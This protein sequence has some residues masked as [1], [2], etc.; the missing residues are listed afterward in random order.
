MKEKW[1]DGPHALTDIRNSIVHPD[2]DKRPEFM[3]DSYYQ[4]CQLSLWYLDLVFLRLC[5]HKGYYANRLLA[6]G[7]CEG[8]VERVP[9]ALS[10][11]SGE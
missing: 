5:G 4:W 3:G 10:D 11:P 2:K 8:Q 6:S 9:W 1:K 7:R